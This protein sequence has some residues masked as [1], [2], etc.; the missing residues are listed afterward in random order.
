MQIDRSFQ[1]IDVHIRGRAVH[2]HGSDDL[3]KARTRRGVDVQEAA[4]VLQPVELD[5]SGTQWNAESIGVEAPG[6]I[7]TGSQRRKQDSLGFGPVFVPPKPFG[8]SMV[9]VKSRIFT[10]LR[11]PP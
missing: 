11:N 8:W 10:L 2:H 6:D 1:S 4:Q 3:L 5:L 9:N 7:L